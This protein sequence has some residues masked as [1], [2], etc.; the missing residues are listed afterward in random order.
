MSD[1]TYIVKTHDESVSDFVF[2]YV[3]KYPVV[4]L[5]RGCVE[6]LEIHM[7]DQFTCIAEVERNM[8]G[9]LLTEFAQMHVG[10]QAK[11]GFIAC[12]LG[13]QG[14][15]L[16]KVGC[17][18]WKKLDIPIDTLANNVQDVHEIMD[19]IKMRLVPFE[20]CECT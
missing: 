13:R 14:C 8:R 10:L 19:F 7:K 1:E 9:C 12:P 16:P 15:M 3:T 6:Q 2:G 17:I 4:K 5:R 18:Q 11:A 20:K